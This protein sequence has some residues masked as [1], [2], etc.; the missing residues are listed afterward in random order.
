MH[1][2]FFYILWAGMIQEDNQSSL[3][4]GS[5]N[6]NPRIDDILDS[7]TNVKSIF[8][9]EAGILEVGESIRKSVHT[10]SL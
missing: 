3:Y 1:S 4:R 8:F 2:P 5:N 7:I 10:A 6:L 9:H